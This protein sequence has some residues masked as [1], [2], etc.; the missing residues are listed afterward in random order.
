MK[1]GVSEAQR[2]TEDAL[3]EAQR[4]TE[5]AA[6]LA[7]A[8]YHD[9][10]EDP[11]FDL[12]ADEENIYDFLMFI[13]P[14]DGAHSH[15]RITIDI[16]MG[17][18]LVMFTLLL[19]GLLLTAVYN[20]VVIGAV[21]WQDGIFKSD[22][23]ADHEKA[24]RLLGVEDPTKCNTGESLCTMNSTGG[25]FECSPPSVRLIGK[26]DELDV[27]HDGVWTRSEA[28]EQRLNLQCKYTIDPEEFFEV[29][30]QLVLRREKIIWI[31]P[32]VR[33]HKAI[34]KTYFDYAKGD[35]IMCG[36][37]NEAMCRNVLKR[38]FFDAPLKHN[39][40]PRVGNTMDS[41]IEYCSDLL[42]TGG[43]CERVLP[44]TYSVWRTQSDE[45]CKGRWYTKFVYTHPVSG[46]EKSFLS[47]DYEAR[48]QAEAEQAP[49]FKVF[50][51]II[52]MVWIMSMV[53]ELKRLCMIYTWLI[54]MPGAKYC[55]DNDLPFCEDRAG[56]GEKDP[57]FRFKLNGI[58]PAH[59]SFMFAVTTL[60]LIML[61][62]LTVVGLSL[63]LHS[64][65]CM[66][67]LFDAIS[68]VFILDLASIMAKYVLRQPVREQTTQVE[69]IEVQLFG[70]SALT[71]RQSVMD[72]GWFAFVVIAAIGVASYYYMAT[73]IPL[74]D[75]LTCTCL[76]T[77]DNCIEAQKFNYD[78]WYNYWR[79]D[80]PKIF[81][82][83]DAMK[84][85][86]ASLLEVDHLTLVGTNVSDG[87]PSSAISKRSVGRLPL[88]KSAGTLVS[89]VA[90]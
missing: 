78:F 44:S 35:I 47:V 50:K 38:G 30:A 75:A 60:R 31:H 56:K 61:S 80:T 84:S 36:Y 89:H 14:T 59:R 17:Y 2:S 8:S 72:M 64:P 71:R 34:P 57:A 10:L 39:T 90:A 48:I 32:D 43:T 12:M 82:D 77:G 7:Q 20:R 74:D 49:D 86:M 1:A 19:Q 15:G 18:I 73:V 4:S 70:P 40:V 27:N 3:H 33:A 24:L 68:L 79:V 88:R 51:A 65:D 85:R 41:A 53:Y 83:V 76:S 66:T 13:S 58:R 87:F 26:W 81:E 52:V 11:T 6:A 28:R 63:L 67:L 69:P 46:A 9:D 16:T 5:D 42:R 23:S 29:I 55:Q 37:R 25:T 54:R 22:G 21:K 62:V 45:E